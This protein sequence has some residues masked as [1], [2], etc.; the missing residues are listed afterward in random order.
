MSSADIDLAASDRA[1]AVRAPAAARVWLALGVYVLST[2]AASGILLA[3]QRPSGI[4][5]AALSLVQFGP[6][7]GA[8]VTWLMFRRTVV[9]VLP[10]AVSRR[11]VGVNLA[12]IVAVCVAY[13]LLITGA[14]VV[15]GT[16][17][18]GPAAVGGVPFVV[19]VVLQFV[20]A[21]GEEV[22]WRGVMQPM[23]ESRMAKAAA[24]SVTG[25]T[26]ALW[27]VQ[28]FTAGAVVTVCF[29]VATMAFAV[30]LGYLGTGSCWQRVL[31]AAVGHGLINVAGYLLAGDSTL[32][33]PQIV[34]VAVAAVLV[35]AGSMGIRA[36][37]RS[38]PSA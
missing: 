3:V 8:L 32:D 19:F 17:I 10:T 29:F 23:L 26:W 21:G 35:A 22:G 36:L 11:W 25:V 27:H 9:R 37:G 20:G 6:A 33:R 5:P 15:S 38:R 12:G 31:V 16:A 13:W 30:V 34:F 24:V 2:L 14:A 1:A 7:V 4:D 18:V 28:A